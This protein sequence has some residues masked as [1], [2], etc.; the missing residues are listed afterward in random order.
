MHKISG[1]ALPAA[2][3]LAGVG[4]LGWV[5]TSTHAR[6]ETAPEVRIDPFQLMMNS[7]ELPVEKFTD[8]SLVFH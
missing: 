6:L 3:F 8:H 2:L 1:F 5:A 7:K 4:G